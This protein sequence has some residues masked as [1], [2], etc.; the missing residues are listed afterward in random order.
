MHNKT[1][2]G[3]RAFTLIELLVVIAIIA[4]LASMLLPALSRAKTR[5]Q[6]AKCMSNL[7]QAGVALHLYLQDYNDRLFWKSTNISID[8]M[9]WFVWAGRT[10]NN[11]IGTAQ[12]NIFNRTDRPLNHYGLT[13]GTVTCPMDQGRTVDGTT[14]DLFEWVGNS[15]VFNCGS[16][17]PAATS[18]GL[19]GLSI[20]S[21]TNLTQTVLFG[22]GILPF[23]AD[24]KGWHRNKPAGNILFADTH[25]SFYQAT[26][27]TNLIW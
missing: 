17:P 20:N 10:N 21:L 1:T 11:K 26:A 2:K 8:G 3:G 27:A 22:C 5:A 24:T 18:P 9:E 16:N 13:E 15:Y 7:R 23:P 19:D 6:D 4:I 25:V 12:D 14:Y